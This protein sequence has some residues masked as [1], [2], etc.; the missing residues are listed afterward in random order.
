MNKPRLEKFEMKYGYFFPLEYKKF[1]LKYGGDTQFGSCR[2]EYPDNMINNI[3]RIPMYM[4]FH[5]IPFGDIGNGDYYCFYRNGAKNDEYFIGIW[6]HETRNFVILASNFKSFL[7]K[8]LLDDYLSTIMPEESYEG[9]SKA[10]IE[11]SLIR[12]NILSN[13]YEYDFEKVKNMKNEFDYHRLMVE[14]DGNAVQSLCFIGKHLLK[15]KNKVGLDFLN[16]AISAYPKYTAP[17]Y[18]AGKSLI[19]SSKSTNEKFIK[20]LNTSLVLTGYS[21]WE[22]DYIELPEDV[23]R[24]IA[25]YMEGKLNN[26]RGFIERGIYLGK[27][28]YDFE[29]RF[30]AAKEHVKEGRYHEAM[31]EYNNSIFCCDNRE[32]VK[33]ILKDALIDAK[34]GNLNYL[35]GILEHDIKVIK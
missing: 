18:I 20:A 13:E 17:Y 14:H 31:V 1:I 16:R 33:D 5:I 22:E 35:L 12:C 24:E 25:L 15:E 4:D 3:V 29:F 8:C 32:T 26:K 6:L 23:H 7:Y 11:E 10:S 21:Y 27:D 9:D 34:K 30:N 2:F 19:N 28:P